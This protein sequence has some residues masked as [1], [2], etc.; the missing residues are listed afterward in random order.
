M[1]IEHAEPFGLAGGAED[2]AERVVQAAGGVVRGAELELIGALGDPGRMLEDAAEVCDEVV[3][4]P[5]ST[6]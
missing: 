2:A 1:G 3:A 5:S 6:A 4:R